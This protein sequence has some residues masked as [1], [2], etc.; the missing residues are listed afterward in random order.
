MEIA[1][2]LTGQLIQVRSKHTHTRTSS[3]D[4]CPEKV[5]DEWKCG[6]LCVTM[7]HLSYKRIKT[8]D[9]ASSETCAAFQGSDESGHQDDPW[10]IVTGSGPAPNGHM[11]QQI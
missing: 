7:T 8:Q 1:L 9:H 6:A 2:N 11:T 10:R 5:Q 4:L 3:L